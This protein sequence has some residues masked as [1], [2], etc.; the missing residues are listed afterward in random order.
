MAQLFAPTLQD[1]KASCHSER[2]LYHVGTG[3]CRECR[4]QQRHTEDPELRE[5]RRETQ[6]NCKR[7]WY[8]RVGASERA[9]E[10]ERYW[11]RGHVYKRDYML[12]SRYGITLEQYAK[13]EADQKG[14][15]AICH[16]PPKNTSRKNRYLCVDHE[17]DTGRVRG[18][19]CRPC[20]AGIGQLCHDVTLLASAILYL[21]RTE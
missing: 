6:R 2:P 7:L 13:M 12:R 17:A 14:L 21:E 10:R 3:L 11:E 16:L 8:Q 15:C 9:K 1:R 18:L 4:E 20:N 5:R 19:L